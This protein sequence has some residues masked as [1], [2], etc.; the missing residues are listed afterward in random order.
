MTSTTHRRP[1]HDPH[2]ARPIVADEQE[3]QNGELLQ[4]QKKAYIDFICRLMLRMDL[5]SLAKMLDAA[6]DMV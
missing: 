5:K 2:R 6:I 1:I 3:D 4:E